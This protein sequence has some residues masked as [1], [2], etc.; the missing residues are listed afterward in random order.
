[1][2]P[3]LALPTRSPGKRR[4]LRMSARGV[5]LGP[6]ERGPPA[7]STRSRPSL[8]AERRDPRKDSC[9]LRIAATIS[10]SETILPSSSTARCGDTAALHPNRVPTL[11]MEAGSCRATTE[12]IPAAATAAWS[13]MPC[14]TPAARATLAPSNSHSLAPTPVCT[15]FT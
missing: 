15:G 3:S 7:I 12:E 14:L 4:G 6:G 8:P 13:P 2:P 9:S 11:S 10:P 5:P 1:M